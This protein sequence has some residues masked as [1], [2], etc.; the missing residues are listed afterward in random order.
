[1]TVMFQKQHKVKSGTLAINRQV[2]TVL[3]VYV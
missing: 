1:M 3:D 2:A